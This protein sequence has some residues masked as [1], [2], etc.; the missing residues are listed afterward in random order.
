MK[1]IYTICTLLSL[2][3]L[4]GLFSCKTDGR[5]EEAQKIVA[6][7]TGKEIRFPDDY[8]CSFAGKDTISSLCANLFQAEYKVL[9]YVDS[10]GCSNGIFVHKGQFQLSG[11]Y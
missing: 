6:E 9:L 11:F 10:A 1:R 2:L 8:Q 3:L 5:K 4:L 7:W